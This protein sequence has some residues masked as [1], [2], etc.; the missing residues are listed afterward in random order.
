MNKKY[1]Q[2]D[3]PISISLEINPPVDADFEKLRKKIDSVSRFVDF[4]NVTSCPMGRLRPSAIASANFIQNKCGVKTVVNVTCRDNN[5][6]GL[7]SDLLGADIL[8]IRNILAVTG[9]P[10]QS[11]SDS[12]F[13]TDVFRLI[14]LAD[15]MNE[16]KTF[17]GKIA[18]KTA[19]R[20]GCATPVPPSGS[21]GIYNRLMRKYESGASFCIT[22][23]IYSVNSL[24]TFL[25]ITE[26]IKIDKIIGLMP[27]T[28][29]KMAK[30]ISKNVPGIYVPDQFLRA[31]EQNK[32]SA[33]EI[34]VAQIKEIIEKAGSRGLLRNISGIHF[35]FYNKGG[36]LLDWAKNYL[37]S[38]NV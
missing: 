36:E 10:A 16:G 28:N 11:P 1:N 25:E 15:D 13:Q 6:L 8:G 24:E 21:Q 27:L 7:A 32:E 12:V 14:K 30:Y 20:I 4:V 34:G 17:S 29:L 22:Q 18:R 31:L 23:P 33:Y 19:F 9:D 5:L 26:S 38:M 2:E 35:M 3:L 37:R